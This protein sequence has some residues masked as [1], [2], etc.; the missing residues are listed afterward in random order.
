MLLA[1]DAVDDVENLLDDA[2]G[3]AEGGLVKHQEARP[4][5]QCAGDRQ[6]LL[7]AARQRTG[8]LVPARGKDGKIA[9]H[10][11][12]VRVR[13]AGAGVAAE[14]QV[15]FDR[16]GHEGSAPFRHVG[17]SEPGDLFRRAPREL[18]PGEADF[19]LAA[20]H[21][22]DG[23]QR[24]RLA[25]AIGAEQNCHA[26]FLDRDIDPVHDFRLAVEGLEAVELEDRRH[27]CRVPR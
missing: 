4:H 5:H 12:D 18:L 15:F 22:A 8:L 14:A 16:E 24:R 17:D 20:D 2:R 26:A 13:P 9:V 19:A 7:L 27:Q 25:R 1:A 10:A 21:A 11:L 23:A 6:H 3:E